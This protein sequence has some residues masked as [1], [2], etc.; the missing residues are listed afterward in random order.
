MLIST[1]TTAM[2][3]M[4]LSLFLVL[5]FTLNK[6][7]DLHRLVLV[8]PLYFFKLFLVNPYLQLQRLQV[9]P[10]NAL[11][12]LKVLVQTISQVLP[13]L[14]IQTHLVPKTLITK[15]LQTQIL[16]T[17]ILTFL[18]DAKRNTAFLLTALLNRSDLQ[19]DRREILR[20]ELRTDHRRP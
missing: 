8:L 13:F 1:S 9:L 18:P 19:P 14:Q 10:N 15:K 11:I 5:L 6:R 7:I 16:I 17:K 20:N 3:S 12:V 2:L 4:S